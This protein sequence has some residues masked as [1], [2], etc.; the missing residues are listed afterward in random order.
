L[1]LGDREFSGTLP[2]PAF[3]TVRLPAGPLKI[4]AQMSNM[5]EISRIVLTPLAATNDTA[6][7]FIVFEKRTPRV[8]VHLGFRRDCGSTF[9]PVGTPQNVG[10]DKPTRYV[11][12]GAMRNF[13]NTEVEKDN[14]NYLAGVREIG[15][16]SE[17]TDGRDMPRLLIK[18]V[19]FEGPFYDSWPPPS[20]RNIFIESQNK[21]QG[22]AAYA[23]DII[24]SFATKAYRRPATNEEVTSLLAVYSK[25]AESGRGF[26]DS[27][28]DALQVAL[29]SPQF[30]FLTDASRTPEA[31]PLDQY[32]LASKLSYFLWNG[33]PD[34][35]TL[36]QAAA[37]TLRKQ[38]DLE[39]SRLIDDP[40]FS[41]FTREF[42]SQWLNLDKFSVLEP[43]RKAFPQLT[44]FTRTQLRDEPIQ[45]VDY[46][47]RKNLPIRNLIAADFVMANETVAGYYGLGDKT[48][49]GFRF[50]P[51][52]HGR[53]ELGGVLT[54]AAIMAGLSDGRESN[55]VK[56]GAWLARKII[57]E[58]PADPPPNVPVLKE[59]N[60]RTL[61][62]RIEQ[63]RSQPAC[64]QCHAKIDPWGIALEEFDAGGRLKEKPA[65]AHSTLPDKT[66]VANVNDLKRY[67]TEARMDQV[68]FSFLK[69]LATYGAGRT[70]TFSELNTLKQDLQKPD[71]LKKDGYRMKDMVRYVVSS[72]VF[73]E[74]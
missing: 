37:G 66:E 71:G 29:T 39:T 9:T 51:V 13:P 57:A 65:D 55:P 7:K 70:L 18:S 74:K 47:L 49:S 4:D 40:K 52:T 60:A 8:G 12:E 41:R 3:L 44:A 33:P 31:E 64:A 27:V 46:L 26:Q 68:A 23:R 6:K 21:Q 38:L 48:E 53:R 28:K 16:R 67:L 1:T 15:V 58:P 32:E 56:R 42:T 50:V 34:A 54:E 17:Y 20:H 14:V 25:S 36:R 35:T 62:E 69:H 59:D 10:S 72:K 73:L 5:S 2:Q 45:F 30:L 19:E 24:R 11:F 63:H 61:R 43:D 22:G